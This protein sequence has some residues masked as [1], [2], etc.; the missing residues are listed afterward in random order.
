[1][2]V[3]RRVLVSE[4]VREACFYQEILNT[5]DVKFGGSGVTNVPGRQALQFV[6]QNQPFHVELT[7]PP[8]GVIYLKPQR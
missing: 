4:A 3:V 5:D 8:L 6:W 7:L 1:M 2:D